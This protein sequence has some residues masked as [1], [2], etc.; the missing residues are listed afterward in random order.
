MTPGQHG[1]YSPPLV[2]AD[3]MTAVLHDRY[4]PDPEDVLRVGEVERPDIDA[5]EVLVRVRAASIDRG[6]W[7]VMAGLPYPVRAAGFGLRRPKDTNPGR[8]LAGVVTAAGA[9]VAGF[10]PG[11]EVF[12]VGRSSFAEYSRARADK[13]AP[14]P[15][16]LS[17]EQA[18]AVPIS[19][20]TALQAVRDQGRVTAGQRVL[21]IGASGGVGTFAVQFA[22]HAGAEVTGVCSG[23]KVDLVRALGAHHV[24]DHT[25]EDVTAGG[26]RYDVVLDIGGNRPLGR[27]RRV[28]TARGRLVLVGGETGGRW[29]GGTDRLLRARLLSPFVGQTLATFLSSENARDLQALRELFESTGLTPVI[30]R[31]LPLDQ[32]AAGMRHLLDGHARGKVVLTIPDGP[33]AS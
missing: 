7:H 2:S 6:T 9:D 33:S 14:K 23:S 5:D 31:T 10:A 18:A 32:V 15:A 8:S 30:D 11:D 12:G 26:R 13:L 4:G 28:L 22:L 3:R 25:R 17:F 19:G 21:V 29:L 16:N 20:L 1:A 27:L 24:I